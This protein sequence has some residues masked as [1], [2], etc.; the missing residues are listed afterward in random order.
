M[1]EMSHCVKQ[2]SRETGGGTQYVDRRQTDALHVFNTQENTKSK[3]LRL[4]EGRQA[5]IKTV[6]GK[7][8]ANRQA[9]NPIQLTKSK[10][11][12]KCPKSTEKHWGKGWNV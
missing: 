8:K 9:G 7:N 12:S 11:Q 5:R 1:E 2:G 3:Y 10:K 4:M 6:Q